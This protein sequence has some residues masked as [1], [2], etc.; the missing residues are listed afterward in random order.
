LLEAGEGDELR[1]ELFLCGLLSQID[2]LLGE[3]LSEALT[4]LRLSRRIGAAVLSQSGPYLPYL[5][6]ATALESPRTEATRALCETHQMNAEDVNRTLLRT[7]A[8]LRLQ[9]D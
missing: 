2:L 3:P 4:R 5:E 6:I 7:L 8:S 1:R 9:F